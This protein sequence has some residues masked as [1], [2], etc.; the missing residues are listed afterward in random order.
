MIKLKFARGNA[1][2]KRDTAIFSLPAGHTCPAAMLCQSRADRITGKLTDGAKTVFRCYAATGE[3]LFRNVRLSRWRNFDALKGL[4]RVA[5]A[6]LINRSLPRKGVKLC[7]IHASGDFFNQAYFDAWLFVARA[8]PSIVFYAYTKALPFWIK[9]IDKIPSNFKLVA[10]RG[11]RYDNLIEAH[12]L[13][14]VRVVCS[15]AEAIQL[16]LLI[17][18]DDCLAWKGDNNF[19][20]LLH[21]T[22][23][24][25]SKMAKVLYALRKAGKGGYKSDYFAHY[26]KKDTLL[27]LAA[28]AVQSRKPVI[29]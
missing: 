19:A 4:D 21:G 8:N 12:N 16:D 15:E 25:G 18:H 1:K 29:A 5:M 7:R 24:K 27:K 23:P 3:N 11:G 9:R 22:Q 26:S 17:D 6:R 20:L 14:N 10:S 13:R 2:L 28:K